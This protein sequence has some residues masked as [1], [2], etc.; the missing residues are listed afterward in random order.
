M[1]YVA[2]VAIMVLLY[3]MCA[4]ALT[5]PLGHA[6]LPWLAQSAVFGI[7]AYAAGVSTVHCGLPFG[8]ALGVATLAGAIAG[9]VIAVPGLRSRPEGFAMVTLLGQ[10]AIVGVLSTWNP[11]S[12]GPLGIAGIPGASILGVSVGRGCAFLM[13]TAVVAAAA[14]LCVTLVQQGRI[15]QLLRAV[16][17]DETLARAQGKPVASL[18]LMAVSV[19]GAVAGVSGALYACYVGYIDPSV[20]SLNNSLLFL[21]M[22][23]LAGSLSPWMAFAGA[24]ILTVLPEA[25][26][27]VGLTDAVV[28]HLRQLVYGVIVVVVVGEWSVV[29]RGKMLGGGRVSGDRVEEETLR[30]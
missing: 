23:L 9:S 29:R 24:A 30:R 4:A 7:G 12:R 15:G 14:V 18:K 8:I 11:V 26:R 25:L 1:E 20:V 6:G 13:L 10:L 17:D 16:R 21:A 22:V 3:G 27:F 28:V 2:H 19:N 5:L